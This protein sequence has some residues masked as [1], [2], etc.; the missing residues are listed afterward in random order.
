MR[1]DRIEIEASFAHKIIS[2]ELGFLGTDAIA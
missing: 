2:Q 1:L